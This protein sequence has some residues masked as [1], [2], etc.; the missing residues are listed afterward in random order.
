MIGTYPAEDDDVLA[1][2]RAYAAKERELQDE[3]ER[4][5]QYHPGYD[6]Y[7]VEAA[8]IWHDPYVLIAIISAYFDGQ[9]WTLE[10]VLQSAIC[11]HTDHYDGNQIPHGTDNR[12]ADRDRPGNG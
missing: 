7:H 2:E 11:R 3:M 12:H 6:E 1:A 10:S 5:E 8:E 9:E 4:Y